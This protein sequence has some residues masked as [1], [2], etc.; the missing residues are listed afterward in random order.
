MEY[1]NQNQFSNFRIH[2]ALLVIKLPLN[3]ILISENTLKWGNITPITQESWV[4]LHYYAATNRSTDQFREVVNPT[5][6]DI[7]HQTVI[8]FCV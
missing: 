5:Y 2:S 4:V 8:N 7:L 3:S 1:F 6:P